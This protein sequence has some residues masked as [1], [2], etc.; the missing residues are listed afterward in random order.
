MGEKLPK[1]WES[2]YFKQVFLKHQCTYKTPWDLVHM[3]IL[4]HQV[5]P[6]LGFCVPSKLPGHANEGRAMS[7]KDLDSRQWRP[8][9]GARV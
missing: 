2:E 4:N 9:T 5:W 8:C 6:W 3:E 7:N 1:L